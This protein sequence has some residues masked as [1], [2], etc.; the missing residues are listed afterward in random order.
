[1]MTLKQAREQLARIERDL[2]TLE[3]NAAAEAAKQWPEGVMKAKT[4][5]FRLRIDTD[6]ARMRAAAEQ[7]RAWI[8]AHYPDA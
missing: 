4:H 8:A 5:F 3:A 1:M 7:G 2:A 6:G